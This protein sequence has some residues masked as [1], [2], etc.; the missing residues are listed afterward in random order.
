MLPLPLQLPPVNLVLRNLQP[1]AGDKLHCLRRSGQS[2]SEL[3]AF[4]GIEVTQH[5]IRRILAARRAANAN[6]HPH[7][8]L[9]AQRLR[10]RARAIVTE[11]VA[12]AAENEKLRG[13]A[14]PAD[15]PTIAE[16]GIAYPGVE[17]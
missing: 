12:L 5:V 14:I 8:V 13:T 1:V 16:L 3:L 9:R 7:V 15:W 4:L 10:G 2:E 6:A 17:G 11:S